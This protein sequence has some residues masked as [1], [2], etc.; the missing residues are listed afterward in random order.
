M[1]DVVARA[2]AKQAND[3]GADLSTQLAEKAT[4]DYVDT[5]VRTIPRGD[6]GEKGDP[7]TAS[8]AI[9]DGMVNAQQT[10]SSLKIEQIPKALMNDLNIVSF[11][12][13][14]KNADF[15]KDTNND[16]VAD[17]W[18]IGS[19]ATNPRLINNTQYWTPANT[20]WGSR[21]G[22]DG[23]YPNIQGRKYYIS[24]KHKNLSVFGWA[25]SSLTKSIP[26]DNAEGQYADIFTIS[27]PSNTYNIFN[28]YGR[29][30]NAESY[31]KEFVFIDL[32]DVFGAGKEPALREI[33]IMLSGFSNKFFSGTKPVFDSKKITERIVSLENQYTFN[34]NRDAE[35]K[36]SNLERLVDF[37]NA[38]DWVATTGTLQT[39]AEI[40]KTGY[41]NDYPIGY[42]SFNSRWDKSMLR[43]DVD[44][45]SVLSR[46]FSPISIDLSSHEILLTIFDD[47]VNALE[48]TDA[49]LF[50]RLYSDYPT[51]QNYFTINY[52]M[53]RCRYRIWES[54]VTHS[55]NATGSPSWNS[56][57]GISIHITPTPGKMSRFYFGGLYRYKKQSKRGA[58]MIDFDDSL[59]S[60]YIEAFDYMT[61][62]KGHRGSVGVVGS[63]VEV[64]NVTY[65][66]GSGTVPTMTID[67]H[68]TMQAGGWDMMNHMY[69]H[70]HASGTIEKITSLVEEGNKWMTDRGL[71]PVGIIPPQ[72]KVNRFTSHLLS[73]YFK[74]SRGRGN[75]GVS[76]PQANLLNIGSVQLSEGTSLESWNNYLLSVQNNKELRSF[77]YHNI[78]VNGYGYTSVAKFRQMIDAIANYDIDVLTYSDIIN[79]KWK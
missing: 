29:V 64:G 13:K 53:Y 22:T 28:F 46:A 42:T 48:Q 51:K 72:N 59:K 5:Q 27:E 7:G 26:I 14:I 21:L 18:V 79:G 35:L 17:N 63:W 76:F 41:P 56:I 62:K 43:L 47:N 20:G 16:G 71:R 74:A 55:H 23:I 52:D 24:F 70:N 10:W 9:D 67:E 32:T 45:D 68:L 77:H 37:T 66:D 61:M 3:K 6:K 65:G 40:D 44:R 8:I 36:A 33:N 4:K 11:E 69:E 54:L 58:I 38:S 25:G 30:G 12:N 39:T 34:P 50:I 73:K 2:L 78:G 15:S 49:K 57:N 31:V 75:L 60:F 1:G 19:T